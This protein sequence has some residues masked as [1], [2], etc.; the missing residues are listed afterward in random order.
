MKKK[1]LVQSHYNV[2]LRS[3]HHTLEAHVEAGNEIVSVTK[4]ND[5]TL[6]GGDYNSYDWLVVVNLKEN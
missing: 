6:Q 1:Q 4:V 2:S 3:M 5:P